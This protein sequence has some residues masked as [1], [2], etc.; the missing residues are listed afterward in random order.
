MR[1]Y[2][3]G[4]D[5][6]APAPIKACPWCG[7]PFNKNSFACVPND[8]AP[9]N[10]TI[11]C[12][13]T[14][15]DF[16][17][18]RPLPILTVDEPIYRRL[19]AFLIATVDKFA[20]LP[21]VAETGA[22]FGHVDH[23]AEGI[24]FYG[25]A[26][27]GHHGRPLDGGWTLDPPDLI[28]QDELHLIAGPLG[29]IAGLYEAAIDQLASRKVGKKRV[30]PKIVASTAT[31]RRASDQIRMLFDRRDTSIFPP[32]GINRTESFFARTVPSSREPARLYLGIAAQGR[33]PKLVFLRALTTLVAAAQAA[34]DACA[35]SSEPGKNPADPYMTAICYFN[36]LRELGGARRIVE[37]EVRD[38]AARYGTQRRRIDPK[39][40]P[41][42]DRQ[43]KEPLEITSRVSTDDVAKAKQRLDAVFG[44]DAEPVDIALATNMIS[45]GLDI[46]RLG[47]MVVQGQP[48][49]AAEYI[50]ATSR[51]GRDLERPGLVVAVLNLHKPRDRTHFEQFRT[52]HRSFYRAVEATSV[53]PWAARALDRALAAVVVAAARHIDPALTLDTAVKEL[54]EP[55]RDPSGSSR[56]HCCTGARQRHSRRWRSAGKPRR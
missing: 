30:R 40:T 16:N 46:L 53:T 43:I 23:F 33:G 44:R 35:G 27:P 21:W 6:R 4:R 48:K 56:C 38:R 9:T 54:E 41:F 18:D 10:L 34:Y 49:T 50:Q 51:I 5:K 12:A 25:A 1:R 55:A 11:R 39:D 37:D 15:C 20:S 52:F 45:V 42:A 8:V 26:D 28:I 36:A 24:G 32:P 13:N 7:T 22:F 17:R 2:R 3:T 19:P 14:A 31:V 29:T 47:L